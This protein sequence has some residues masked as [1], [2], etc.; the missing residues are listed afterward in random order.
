MA[1]RK[2]DWTFQQMHGLMPYEIDEIAVIAGGLPLANR[3]RAAAAGK[4]FMRLMLG[5]R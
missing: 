4:I 1:I 5:D 2:C 3:T